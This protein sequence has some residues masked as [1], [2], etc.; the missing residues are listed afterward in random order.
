MVRA[1]GLLIVQVFNLFGLNMGQMPATRPRPLILRRQIYQFKQGSWHWLG[2][3]D[4]AYP[5]AADRFCR[6]WPA[7]LEKRLQSRVQHPVPQDA[8]KDSACAS[9]V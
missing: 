6:V 7:L 8:H 9:V 2:E 3:R 1:G 5:A 4:Y